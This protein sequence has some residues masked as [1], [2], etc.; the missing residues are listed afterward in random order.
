MLGHPGIFLDHDD[1]RPRTGVGAAQIRAD[2]GAAIRIFN[3]IR[4]DRR[5]NGDQ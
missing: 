2:R 1:F 3:P 4:F 5:G